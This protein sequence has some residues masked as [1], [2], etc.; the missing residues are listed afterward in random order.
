MSVP[1]SY[2]F[3]QNPDAIDA[4][5]GTP[6]V[7]EDTIYVGQWQGAAIPLADPSA[8]EGLVAIGP[9]GWTT[10][11][12]ATTDGPVAAEKLLF[13]SPSSASEPTVLALE[14]ADT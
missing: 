14:D 10:T 12:V 4:G 11:E 9:D 5:W 6:T 3:H 1:D 2:D 8:V 7:T 13:L